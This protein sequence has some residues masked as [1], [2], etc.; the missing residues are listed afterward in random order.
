MLGIAAGLRQI[1]VIAALLVAL[2]APAAAQQPSPEKEQLI[3]EFFKTVRVME[4]VDQ[5]IPTATTGI[6]QQF[7]VLVP[8]LTDAHIADLSRIMVEEF[9]AHQ[10]SFE[11]LMVLVYDKHFTKEELEAAI[12]FYRTPAGASLAAKMPIVSQ[13]GMLVG[14][15]WGAEVGRRAADRAIKSARD[16]G[17]KL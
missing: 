10:T 14:Q 17:Y 1:L 6:L 16:L 2:A 13:E 15:R 5:M 9:K 11:T 3:R 7:R 4:V 12:A 8:N